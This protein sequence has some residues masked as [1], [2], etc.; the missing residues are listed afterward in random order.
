M[1]RG[2]MFFAWDPRE[3]F[4]VWISGGALFSGVTLAGSVLLREASLA[5]LGVLG[6]VY[7]AMG[8]VVW[9]TARTV[10]HA[11]EGAR[12]AGRDVWSVSAQSD[13]DRRYR[14]GTLEATDLELRLTLKPETVLLNWS[15]ITSITLRAGRLFSS[16]RLLIVVP[17]RGTLFL[18]VLAANSVASISDAGLQGCN[19]R[20]NQF[21]SRSL[22]RS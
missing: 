2:K 8:L 4:L 15:E 11:V 20:L 21:K 19:E 16:G 13:R 5:V 3:N 22:S 7:V 12:R 6:F 10:R 14:L 9:W 1:T 18:D 17:T